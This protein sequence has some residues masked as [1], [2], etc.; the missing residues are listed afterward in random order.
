MHTRL[1]WY[2]SLG[3][4]FCRNH[5]PAR[6]IVTDAL[7]CRHTGFFAY[8]RGLYAGRFFKLLIFEPFVDLA[9]NGTPDQLRIRG[10]PAVL[11]SIIIKAAPDNEAVI[12]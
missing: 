6:I 3:K 12:R 1:L 5:A 8:F 9:H 7:L 2:R 10:C 4:I 11:L